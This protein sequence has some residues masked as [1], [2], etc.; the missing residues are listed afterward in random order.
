LWQAPA[1]VVAAVV[2][3]VAVATLAA[4]AISAGAAVSAATAGLPAARFQL[5]GRNRGEAKRV[6]HPVFRKMK[7]S[8]QAGRACR[9]SAE[10]SRLAAVHLLNPADSPNAA[11]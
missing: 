10:V 8:V 5:L 6:H 11:R 9:L 1:L 2:V 4:A 3:V 7:A